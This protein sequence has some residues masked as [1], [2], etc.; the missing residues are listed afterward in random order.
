MSVNNNGDLPT[1]SH[2]MWRAKGSELEISSSDPKFKKR[3]IYYVG[4]NVR[5]DNPPANH[6]YHITYS[7]KEKSAEAN[8]VHTFLSPNTPSY[9]VVNIFTVVVEKK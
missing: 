1:S 6:T 9:G 3:G 7:L 4:V 2:E 5:D 8:P